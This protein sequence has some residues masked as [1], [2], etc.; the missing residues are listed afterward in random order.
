MSADVDWMDYGVARNL[1]DAQTRINL[2]GNRLV[3]I[4]GK[5]TKIDAVTIG[6]GFDLA[7]L[8]GDGRIVT[9]DVRAVPAGKYAAAPAKANAPSWMS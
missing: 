7:K 6:P 5:D 8:V 4:A 2:L 9:A 1:I 3:L